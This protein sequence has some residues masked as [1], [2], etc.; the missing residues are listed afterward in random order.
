MGE[1]KQVSAVE[2]KRWELSTARLNQVLEL[3]RRT[4]FPA[5]QVMAVRELI[6][7]F[8]GSRNEVFSEAGK[9]L[10]E[11]FERL[12]GSLQPT[13][14]KGMKQT[15]KILADAKQECENAT[16]VREIYNDIKILNYDKY[17]NPENAAERRVTSFRVAYSANMGF[18][19]IFEIGNGWG[20]PF[21]TKKG[22]TMVKEGTVRIVDKVQIFIQEQY[23]F[24]LLRRVQLFIETMTAQ[25]MQKYYEKVSEPMLQVYDT[26]E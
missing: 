17:I 26:Q 20:Q 9:K 24:P 10:S 23:L 22:G 1:V 25:A 12:V 3:Y 4:V 15:E 18:P 19:F 11:A 16:K 5:E 2:K 6:E 21:I 13:F 14:E 7:Q 8:S